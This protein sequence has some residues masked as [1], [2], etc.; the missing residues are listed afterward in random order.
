MAAH[1]LRV[2]VATIAAMALALVLTLAGLTAALAS[3]GI[4]SPSQ[5][6]Q[7]GLA[8]AFADKAPELAPAI[9]SVGAIVAALSFLFLAGLG[10]AALWARSRARTASVRT[11]ETRETP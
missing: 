4:D 6:A 1:L 5:A 3:R 2:F 7:I 10:V 11:T 9:L 8:Q